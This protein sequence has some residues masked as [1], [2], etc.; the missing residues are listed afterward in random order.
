MKVDAKR[1]QDLVKRA[2][3]CCDNKAS[4]VMWRGVALWDDGGMLAAGS[5][6]SA[7]SIRLRSDWKIADLGDAPLMFSP[8]DLN[9][10]LGVFY[11]DVE[12]TFKDGKLQFAGGVSKASVPILELQLD[13]HGA[14][15]MLNA[16]S[17]EFFCAPG[18]E[19]AKQLTAAATCASGDETRPILTGVCVEVIGS[20]VNF[21]AT[22]THRLVKASLSEKAQTGSMPGTAIIPPFAFK[23]IADICKGK[24]LVVCQAFK[25]G[26]EINRLVFIAG[27]EMMETCTVEGSFPRYERVIPA[28]LEDD[29]I[30]SGHADLIKDVFNRV[31]PFSASAA[32]KDRAIVRFK[33][34]AASVEA[35]GDAGEASISLYQS[36]V[37]GPEEAD[38]SYAV[39]CRYMIDALSPLGGN[40]VEIRFKTGK[41]GN[42]QP[43]LIYGQTDRLTGVVMPM[44][45]Q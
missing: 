19:I 45:L 1:F 10:A 15:E 21:V 3:S 34:D 41:Q 40:S 13:G 11:G 23:P 22:D 7:Q 29:I 25:A 38:E 2:A 42:L 24:E 26:N 5:S 18:D 27:N 28:A 35:L 6:C 8:K 32:A 43:I 37:T 33:G 44:Q 16:N 12:V 14:L 17:E 4:L 39:N 31:A 30:L 9:N 36:T 20:C